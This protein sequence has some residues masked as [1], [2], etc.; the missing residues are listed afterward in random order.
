MGK[1]YRSYWEIRIKV[2]KTG[3]VSGKSK[4]AKVLSLIRILILLKDN[5]RVKWIFIEI[6]MN[7]MLIGWH[8]L[9][10]SL[11]IW[12]KMKERNL[13][14]WTINSL[15]KSKKISQLIIIIYLCY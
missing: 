5:R 9:Q 11:I 1:N 7:L 12:Y 13:I 15:I 14:Q 8:N 2:I 10:V 3:L 4:W 6:L